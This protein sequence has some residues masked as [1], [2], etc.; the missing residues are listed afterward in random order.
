MHSPSAVFLIM[1]SLA[2]LASAE[3]IRSAHGNAYGSDGRLLFTQTHYWYDDAAGE[4]SGFTLYTCPDGRAFARRL[5]DYGTHPDTPDFA[6]DIA[7]TGYREG[8]RTEGAQRIV[9]VQRGAGQPQQDAPLPIAEHAVIDDG[10]NAYVAA[11]WDAL[12][13]GRDVRVDYLV[14]SRHRF[15]GFR[16]VKVDDANGNELHLRMQFDFWFGRFLP[17]V[18]LVYD[19]ATRN[20]VRYQGISNIRDADGDNVHVRIESPLDERRDDVPRAQLD[21]ALATP[22]DG[23]CAM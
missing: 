19:R 5:S 8:V 4:P 7:Q 12:L 16:V 21:A 11:H 9:Y 18:S 2:G 15:Y 6:L 3:P 22:L 14:P 13:D 10:F 20:L 1:V 17:H 23:H